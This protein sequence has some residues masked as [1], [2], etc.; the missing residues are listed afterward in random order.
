MDI[1]VQAVS[2]MKEHARK[3]INM[4]HSPRHMFASMAE[5]AQG[6]GACLTCNK[7]C[8]LSTRPDLVVCGLSCH[9]VSSLRHTKGDTSRMKTAEEHPEY[10]L[11]FVEFLQF[12]DKRRPRAFLVEQVPGLLRKATS[13]DESYLH[14]FM[15][16]TAQRG[17]HVQCLTADAGMWVSWPRERLYIYGLVE[18]LG[19]EEG[20]ALVKEAIEDW[21]AVADVSYKVSR[22]CVHVPCVCVVTAPTSKRD[23]NET[24]MQPHTQASCT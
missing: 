8:E 23:R 1:V 18:E 17:Y 16:L 13:M 14:H 24:C 7:R 22:T 2:E 6:A 12:L 15:R 3:Y 19:G 11:M 9:P 5:H 21:L 4:N 10:K 20:V